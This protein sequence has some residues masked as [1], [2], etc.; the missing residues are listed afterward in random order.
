MITDFLQRVVMFPDGLM[1]ELIPCS[2]VLSIREEPLKSW[3]SCISFA[4]E[5]V[6]I[7]RRA[8]E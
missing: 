5:D 8:S 4:P 2:P 7:H 3:P 6:W 1:D